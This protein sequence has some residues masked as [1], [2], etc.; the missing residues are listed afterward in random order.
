MANQ[1][2]LLLIV[3]EGADR[4]APQRA[5]KARVI[6]SSRCQVVLAD[7]RQVTLMM[8]PKLKAARVLPFWITTA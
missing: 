3:P 1:N 2:P 8:S 5:Y 7:N 6:Q 4:R